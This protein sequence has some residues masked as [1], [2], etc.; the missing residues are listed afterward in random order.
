[1]SLLSLEKLF[2]HSR[3]RLPL[4]ILTIV[5]GVG[6]FIEP[7]IFL[8]MIFI[9]LLGLLMVFETIHPNGYPTHLYNP[10][11]QLLPKKLQFPISF[12]LRMIGILL[13][14]FLM[15]LGISVGISWYIH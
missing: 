6:F 13:G 5:T 11:V 7:N 8:P 9:T 14:L 12:L 10:I 3:L 15:F 2:V 4:Y 1:L